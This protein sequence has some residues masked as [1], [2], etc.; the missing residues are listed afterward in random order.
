MSGPITLY[1]KQATNF[2]STAHCI[3]P[4]DCVLSCNVTESTDGTYELSLE[5]HVNS[6]MAAEFDVERI[7]VCYANRETNRT[8]QAFRIYQIAY[9]DATKIS[10][11][12]YHISY[13][14]GYFKIPNVV[15]PKPGFEDDTATAPADKNWFKYFWDATYGKWIAIASGQS[16]ETWTG[17][18]D[19]SAF[20]PNL[21]PW[22][23]TETGGSNLTTKADI[24]AVLAVSDKTMLN[25]YTASVDINTGARQVFTGE[26][27]NG[28][29]DI[30]N[31]GEHNHKKYFTWNN[32]NITYSERGY[33]TAANPKKL[34]YGK[35]IA[36]YSQDKNLDDIYTGCIGFRKTTVKGISENYD[37]A[38]LVTETYIKVATGYENA[39]CPRYYM[40]DC[41]EDEGELEDLVSTWM[42]VNAS[43]IGAPNVELSLDYI[44]MSASQTYA[45]WAREP[46]FLCERVSIYF[47]SLNS[48]VTS[49][50]NEIEYDVLNDKITSVTLGN[51]ESF[52]DLIYAMNQKVT[53]NKETSVAD[54]VENLLTGATTQKKC[55]VTRI[56]ASNLYGNFTDHM[57]RSI[58]AVI[59]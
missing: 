5:C 32:F 54:E 41:S 47:P 36:T 40:L 23:F 51:E 11:S 3:G 16:Q 52:E 7:I 13:D 42:T 21:G 17:V 38:S 37:G 44:D 35:E 45:Q 50:V 22:T 4:I 49:M 57:G 12:A 31:I 14:L 46:V 56:N 6:N 34:I 24:S 59:K 53:D 33:E 8:R 39:P 15:F 28:F 18:E 25:D 30:L 55:T 2:T 20:Y 58:R 29:Y 10:I 43:K 48:W 19:P 27:S 26:D 1:D 9:S